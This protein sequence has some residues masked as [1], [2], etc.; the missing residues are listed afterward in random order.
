MPFAFINWMKSAIHFDSLGLSPIALDLGIWHLFG[1][2]FHPMIHWYALAYIG[3]ILLAWRYV[4]LLLKQPGAPMTPIQTEDLVFWA[5]LGILVGGR[6]AYVFFYQPSML[7][8]P[9]EILKLWEGGMS[10]HGG[11]VGVFLAIWWVKWRNGLSWLRIADYIGCATP[12]GLFLGRIANFINGELWGRPSTLP[13]AIIFPQAGPLPRHPSQLYEAG[14]EGI[15]L[16]IFLN[17]MF[18]A[19]KAR[20]QPGKLAGFFLVGYGLSRFIVEW[21]R[22]PDV[23]LGTLSWGLTMGQTLTIPMVLAGLWL[24]LTASKRPPVFAAN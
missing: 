4:L 10:Y 16:F 20:L 1:L 5:T 13:W 22:E 15:L 11:M 6:L 14:L 21:F 7:S 2:T 3:G 17:C 24:I 19:T 12:I 18:F 23:Q 9:S 8:T